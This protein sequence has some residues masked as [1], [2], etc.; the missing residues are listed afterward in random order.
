MVNLNLR[1]VIIPQAFR[2][3][4]ADRRNQLLIAHLELE[5]H[6]HIEDQ[7]GMGRTAV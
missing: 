7:V 1:V 2:D 6:Q 4:S 5:R 3:S